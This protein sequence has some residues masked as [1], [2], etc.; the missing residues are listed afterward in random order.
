MFLPVLS[1]N[2]NQ[3]L[4]RKLRLLCVLFLQFSAMRS[5]IWS[6]TCSKTTTRISARWFIL[7][8]RWRFRS[9]WPSLTSSLW[10]DKFTILPTINTYS[11]NIHYSFFIYTTEW[12][13]GDSDDQRV[14]WDCEF[15]LSMLRLPAG[16]LRVLLTFSPLS[17]AEFWMSLLTFLS[18][19]IYSSGLI[20]AL[21][22]THQ[23]IT[24]SILFVSLATLCGFLTLSLRTSKAVTKTSVLQCLYTLLCIM[25]SAVL[26]LYP[27]SLQ[28]WWKLWCGLL[29]QCVD[30]QRWLDVLAA[31]C[32]LSQHLCHRDHLF[33]VWLSKLHASIQ[34]WTLLNILHVLHV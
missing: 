29:R 17:C 34:V 8:T 25:S 14:D 21:P 22:G 31:S 10:W 18:N 12:K 33:P 23:T 7:K 26:V 20:I 9:S 28:H 6:E 24:A 15:P 4:L 13:G 27:Q 5:H 30:Q 32:Y 3:T 11:S 2:I 1:W 16:L 19:V